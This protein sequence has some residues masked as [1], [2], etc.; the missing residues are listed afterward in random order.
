MSAKSNSTTSGGEIMHKID[1]DELK[2]GMKFDKSI[3]HSSGTEILSAGVELTKGM[4]KI[5]KGRG[6]K[7]IYTESQ[8]FASGSGENGQEEGAPRGYIQRRI[9]LSQVKP[10]MELA[11][12][13]YQDRKVLIEKGV[14][15]T[16]FLINSPF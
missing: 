12:P 3:C 8:P 14:I 4:I 10:G 2:P 15:L 6:V 7:S 1:V 9:E 13:V 16:N 5:L 11:Q